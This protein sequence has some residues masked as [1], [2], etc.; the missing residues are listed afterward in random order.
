MW[1]TRGN[2][3]YLY[4]SQRVR[5]TPTTVYVGTGPVADRLFAEVEDR[6][7]ARQAVAEAGAARGA[8][9]RA[10]E[11]PLDELCDQAD[12][13]VAAALLALGFHRHDRSKW[14][15]RRERPETE[16]GRPDPAADPSRG[17]GGDR[18]G[19]RG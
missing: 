10:A 16:A 14:R 5:G 11:E 8:A 9:G 3:S 19:E 2:R 1:V 15:K 4:L 6:K 12:Q 17:P 13:V 7:H 18:G